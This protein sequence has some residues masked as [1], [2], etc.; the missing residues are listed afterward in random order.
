VR[1]KCDIKNPLQDKPF[2]LFVSYLRFKKSVEKQ[3]FY[4]HITSHEIFGSKS[5]LS[6][7]FHVIVDAVGNPSIQKRFQYPVFLDFHKRVM[8]CETFVA[9]R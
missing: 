2:R 8:C 3:I 4:L 1:D 5:S 9:G 6:F 7:R